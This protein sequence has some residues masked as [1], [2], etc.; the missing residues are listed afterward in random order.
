MR[1]ECK[2]CGLCKNVTSEP[3]EEYI[4]LIDDNIDLKENKNSATE[5]KYYQQP[6]EYIELVGDFEDK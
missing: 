3:L 4:E 5:I 1:E 6:K 2:K